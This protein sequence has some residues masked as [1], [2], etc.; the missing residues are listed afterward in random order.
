MYGQSTTLSAEDC[1]FT[2]SLSYTDSACRTTLESICSN[3]IVNTI[4]SNLFVFIIEMF[5]GKTYILS[6]LHEILRIIIF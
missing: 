2:L 1:K 5:K 6:G 3:T 4:D